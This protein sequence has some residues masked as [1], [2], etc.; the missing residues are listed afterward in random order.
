MNNRIAAIETAI[1]VVIRYEP[2][3][4]PEFVYELT[5]DEQALVKRYLQR[6][7]EQIK[8]NLLNVIHLAINRDRFLKSELRDNLKIALGN[9]NDDDFIEKIMELF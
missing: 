2:E 6:N 1:E 7:N 8:E 4:C 3:D 5:G 9:Y